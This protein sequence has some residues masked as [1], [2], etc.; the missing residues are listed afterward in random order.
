MSFRPLPFSK[1]ARSR[2]IKQQSTATILHLI[3]AIVELVTNSDDSYSRLESMGKRPSGKIEIYVKRE[4]GGKCKELKIRDYA[5][6]IENLE[7]AIGYGEESSGF[8]KG[9]T[10]RGLLG[11]GLKEGIVGLGEGE[12]YTR[13][14]GIRQGVKIY[15]KQGVIGYDSIDTGNSDKN[16]TDP[17]IIEFL[18]SKGNG[19]FIKIRVKNEKI[20]IPESDKFKLQIANHYAL[21][22]INSST[23]REIILTFEGFGRS[24]RRRTRTSSQ[25]KFISPKGK[26][27]INKS[28]LL[29]NYKDLIQ[30]RVYESPRPLSFQRH[31]PCS[32]AGILIKTRGATLDNRLFR[33][34]N[35]PAAFYFWGEAYCEG[36]ASRLMKV[37]KRGGESEIIDLTRKGLNWGSEYCKALQKTIEKQLTPFI[38][39]K[40]KEL[41]KGERRVMSRATKK[42][43]K[44]ICK[45][46]DRLAKKEFKEWEGPS[47]KEFTEL[48]IIPEYANIEISKSRALS[49]YAPKELIKIAGN[50]ISVWSGTSDVKILLPGTKRSGLLWTFSLDPHPTNPN[51]CYKFFKVI[52]YEIGKEALIYSK[53][54][55]Q[56]AT[57]TV[58]VVRELLKGAETT[59]TKKKKR[60]GFIGKIEQSGSLS[61]IQRVEYN[62]KSGIIKIYIKFP[63]VARYFPSGLKEIEHKEESRV[64]LAELI[65]EAFCKALA[66][67]K[68]E[69]GGIS[70]NPEAQID[71]FNSEVNNMQKR[72]LD[73]IHELILN[74][75]FK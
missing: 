36:I 35:N 40:E 37:A 7:K 23:N 48:T 30:L 52:G 4:K 54:G 74:R 20:K 42:M 17:D 27:I 22:D 21:R 49:I 75:K 72:Y 32:A 34:E 53:L 69:T 67:K 28:I 47:S 50:Q 61:P 19:T 62:E 71:A 1:R 64:M 33:Y 38:Q 2:V 73:K 55:L 58:R 5:E 24:G 16:K 70:V 59:K 18:N 46:L 31:D 44:D 43:L 57:A 25:V 63:G 39:S 65:G 10:V 11:R 12:I 26:P 60:G 51:V 13:K 45:L 41:E 66:R 8:T 15:E 29:P 14:Q 68:L 9:K 56:Q 3:D 6:G